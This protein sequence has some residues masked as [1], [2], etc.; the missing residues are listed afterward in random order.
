MAVHLQIELC[1][2][3]QQTL[4][5]EVADCTV[6]DVTVLVLGKAV[7]KQTSAVHHEPQISKARISA[8]CL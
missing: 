3:Y 1:V 7:L 5:D 6:H 4:G 8:V 2:V